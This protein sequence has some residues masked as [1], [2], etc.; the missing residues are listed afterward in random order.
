MR[1]GLVRLDHKGLYKESVH[2]SVV[3]AYLL[4]APPFTLKRV[5]ILVVNYAGTLL[6]RHTREFEFYPRSE[7][8][9]LSI[10]NRASTG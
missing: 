4:P 3:P 8:E 5:L 1:G 7:E 9:P 10:L 2:M 6:V